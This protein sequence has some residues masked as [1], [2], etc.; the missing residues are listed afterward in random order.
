MDWLAVHAVLGEPVSGSFFAITGK[1]TGKKEK[2]ALWDH[3]R[4]Q[5]RSIYGPFGGF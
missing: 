5:L 3:P 1:N 2:I 4:M